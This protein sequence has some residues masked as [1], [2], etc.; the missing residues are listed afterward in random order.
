MN[1]GI[2][3]LFTQPFGGK[4]IRVLK[5]N[6]AGGVML[7]ITVLSILLVIL[8]GLGLYLKSVPVFENNSFWH[9]IT[10]SDWK[11]GKGEF[12]FLPFIAGTL[13]IT[14]IAVI[15][16]LPIALLSA[17]FLNEYSK[18]AVK[19]WVFTAL[20]ILAG[21]PSVVYG[22]WGTLFIVPWISEKL[23]PHFVE[24]S[25]GYTV[26][27]GGIVLGVMILPLLISLFVE[28]FS[29]V[30]RE[31][32]DASLSL[33]ATKW[34]TC[35]HV[36]LRKT[37]PGILAA[38]ILAVSRAFGETIAVLMVCGN[39]PLLPHSLFDSCYPLP[40]LIANNYGEMLSV[41]LYESVLM[42]AAFLLFI[43]V[44]IF[45]ATSRAVIYRIERKFK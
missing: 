26:L 9:L 20:D 24:Y 33:G 36:I 34:Q 41:P 18:T 7:S 28:I 2:K 25:T 6:I 14:T 22:V 40:A 16:A 17:L 35:K 13:S 1:N 43:V 44:F 15:L 39:I 12:G 45:N 4:G 11:P 29:A 37:F 31:Y 19:K 42:L 5:N 30:P 10:S 3:S 27:A 8:I 38:L 32:R 21:I 23:A